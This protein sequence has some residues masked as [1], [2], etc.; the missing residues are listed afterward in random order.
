MAK[1]SRPAE[2]VTVAE[3][4]Q[5]VLKAIAEKF[6]D[7]PL[8]VDTAKKGLAHA[9]FTLIEMHLREVAERAKK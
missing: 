1:R 3:V 5:A 4:E 7:R 9:G 6:G 8:D 2:P